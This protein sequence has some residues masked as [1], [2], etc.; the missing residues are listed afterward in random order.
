[1]ALFSTFWMEDIDFHFILGPTNY[2]AKFGTHKY[3]VEAV[4]INEVS[5]VPKTSP[6]TS[7]MS[8]EYLWKVMQV[9]KWKK[10]TQHKCKNNDL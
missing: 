3:S 5:Q 1:M 7:Q 10:N 9:I 2:V 6:E 4:W 8:K